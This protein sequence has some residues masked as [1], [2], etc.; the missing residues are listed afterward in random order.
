MQR[1]LNRIPDQTKVNDNFKTLVFDLNFNKLFNS[2]IDTL[3]NEG[4]A[5]LDENIKIKK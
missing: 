1:N 3:M 5:I 2:H 4:Q